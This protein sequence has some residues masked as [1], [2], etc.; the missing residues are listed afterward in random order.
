MAGSGQGTSVKTV[1][2]G[3]VGRKARSDVFEEQHKKAAGRPAKV[4]RTHLLNKKTEKKKAEEKA[5]KQAKK[6]AGAKKVAEEKHVLGMIIA[7]RVEQSI[8]LPLAGTRLR[9]TLPL[10]CRSR[11]P[12]YDSS[13][14][15]AHRGAPRCLEA[16]FQLILH[17]FA[18]GSTGRPPCY[19]SL[20]VS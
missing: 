12:A 3:A 7:M 10:E 17:P 6:L 15:A 4:K 9:A 14:M 19:R 13:R 1:A 8:D 16:F 5:G 2:K 20:C 11:N 18:D